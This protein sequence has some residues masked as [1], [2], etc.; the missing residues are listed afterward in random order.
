MKNKTKLENLI[1]RR[2]TYK[3][4][5]STIDGKLV[6]DE[7]LKYCKM[8]DISMGAT[9]SVTAF[10]EG[11]RSVGLHILHILGQNDHALEHISKKLEEQY[12]NQILDE[13]I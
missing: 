6:L 11:R 7:V 12:Q 10:N 4:V 1:K 9:P 8:Y 5:Y 13:V 2:D 3:R